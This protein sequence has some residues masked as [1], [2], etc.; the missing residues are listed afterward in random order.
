MNSELHG[1]ETNGLYHLN[2]N[3]GHSFELNSAVVLPGQFAGNFTGR[4]I[5]ICDE[6]PLFVIPWTVVTL[7]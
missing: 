6:T 3:V 1:T 2:S 4:Y 5:Y 7:E